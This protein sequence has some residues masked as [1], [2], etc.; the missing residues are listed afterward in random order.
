MHKYILKRL[1]MLLP[2]LLGVSFIVFAI[3]DFSPGD[4]VQLYLGDNYSQEAYDEISEELGL[5]D[6]FLVRYFRYVTHAVTG[7]LGT[8]YSTK[9]PVAKEIFARYP[10]TLRLAG[11]AIFF[12]VILGIPLGI[13]SAT[14]Q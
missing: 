8:S 2:V 4:P 11:A 14:K 9:N 5:N 6:P 7:D 10:A 12:A 3:M 1:L 13:I